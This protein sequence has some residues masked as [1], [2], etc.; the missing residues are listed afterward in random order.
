MN[1]RKI[2]TRWIF[3]SDVFFCRYI[4]NAASKDFQNIYITCVKVKAGTKRDV[5]KVGQA[6]CR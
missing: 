4:F 3:R 2:E 1:K 5:C 6:F